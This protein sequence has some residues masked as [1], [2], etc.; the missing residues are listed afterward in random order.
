MLR[1]RR[2]ALQTSVAAIHKTL[3][4][5]VRPPAGEER[6]DGE[7]DQGND[8]DAP[9]D[10]GAE[11]GDIVM[12]VEVPLSSLQV[13]H[14]VGPVGEDFGDHSEPI[15]AV[16]P[17]HVDVVA[18]VVVT[19]ERGNGSL[20]VVAKVIP[21][22]AVA[23]EVIPLPAHLTLATA[24]VAIGA[25]VLDLLAFP[26]RLGPL[27]IAMV[28]S[29]HRLALRVRIRVRPELDVRAQD[30]RLAVAPHAAPHGGQRRHGEH[31]RCRERGTGEAEPGAAN[32][33]LGLPGCAKVTFLDTAQEALVLH[34]RSVVVNRCCRHTAAYAMTGERLSA[35]PRRLCQS[36]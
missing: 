30:M 36:A 28:G 34:L 19:V 5:L 10:I 18:D 14:V 13:A 9:P 7:H 12:M 8:Q 23:A 4:H 22:P 29:A 6:H 11:D 17:L 3:R 32:A 21:L 1:S 25:I 33:R 35:S 31:R 27:A 20:A 15:V 16:R 2:P 26:R 24:M